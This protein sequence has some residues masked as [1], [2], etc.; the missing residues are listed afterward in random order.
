MTRPTI[1][2]PCED[3]QGEETGRQEFRSPCGPGRIRNDAGDCVLAASLPALPV[4]VPIRVPPEDPFPENVLRSERD[5]NRLDP[6]Q[7]TNIEDILYSSAIRDISSINEEIFYNIDPVVIRDRMIIELAA[8]HSSLWYN[9]KTAEVTDFVDRFRLA[10]MNIWH[11]NQIYSSQNLILRAV[12]NPRIEGQITNLQHNL[13]NP[14]AASV[15][16]AIHEDARRPYTV[17]PIEGDS[18]YDRME[19]FPFVFDLDRVAR[20]RMTQGFPDVSTVGQYMD[21]YIEGLA[22]PFWQVGE[23][24]PDFWESKPDLRDL[25][26][27]GNL[28]YDKEFFDYTF[29]APVAFFESEMDN[30]LVSPFDSAD[31]TVSAQSQEIYQDIESELELPSVYQYYQA[32]QVE[33]VIGDDERLQQNLPPG[34]VEFNQ[35]VS[36]NFEEFV[37]ENQF[38]SKSAFKFPSDKV[39]KLEEINEIIRGSVPNYVEISINTTQAGPINAALQRNKMDIIVLEAF[40]YNNPKRGEPDASPEQQQA[41]VVTNREQTIFFTKVLDDKFITADNVDQEEVNV[42]VNDRAVQGLSEF[43]IRDIDKII[44][45]CSSIQL[46]EFSWP[47]NLEEYPLYYSG[48]ESKA[49]LQLEE[50]IRSQIFLSQLETSL[51]DNKLERT[52]ADV[53]YGNKAYSEVVGYKV[54]KY[55]IDTNEQNQEI[56]NKIQDFF[57]MDNDSVERFSF[58]DSQVLPD[59][60]YKYKIFTINFV[61]GTRYEYSSD[62]FRYYWRD[63]GQGLR[64]PGKEDPRFS[65]GVYSGNVISLIKAPFFEKT[66]SLADKPPLFPQVTF[67]PYQGVDNRHA[68]LLQSNN[69]ETLQKPIE[70][71]EADADII[72]STYR[73]QNRRPGSEVLY[74]SDSLPTHFEAVRIEEE[75]ETY[76]DFSS[77][78]ALVVKK[79]ANGKTAFCIFDVEPNKYYYYIFRTYDEGGVSNPTEVFRVRMVSYQNGIFMEMEPY[80]MYKKPEEFKMSFERMLKIS[81]SADQKIINFEKVFDNIRNNEEDGSVLTKIRRELDIITPI[82]SAEFQ[83]TAPPIDDL[84]L[85]NKNAEDTVWGKTFKVRC[86]SK[87]TGKKIDINIT[88]DKS[89]TT[90]V[91][92]R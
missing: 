79:P 44:S 26:I 61:I 50:L 24:M 40:N 87:T 28:E 73:S 67:L 80:E 32:K 54:E 27:P 53:L 3:L 72:A 19:T 39:E 15:M 45:T 37:N 76:G 46:R 17:Q 13:M 88:F 10:L 30:I 81:P 64:P 22:S 25:Y 47:R 4:V 29:D 43:T 91:P 60:K 82:N 52:F 74:R 8:N 23:G 9:Q 69:G 85:G 57:F 78:N 31:I 84:E 62:D 71:F 11:F 6:E 38:T 21:T 35:R 16:F 90:L 56:E 66:V 5:F 48:W 1:E 92:D 89:K 20:A 41:R 58:I 36:V 51:K 70:I 14:I 75:P 34:L 77:P 2:N 7:N 65:L 49:R 63:D 59:K 33:R 83:S 12:G 86:I 42:T 18:F 55:R 68:V